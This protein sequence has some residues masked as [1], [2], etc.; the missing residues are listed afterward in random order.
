[1]LSEQL[2]FWSSKFIVTEGD[3]MIDISS[4]AKGM[5]S[6]VPVGA[7]QQ[8]M[9]PYP[10]TFYRFDPCI[11][12]GQNTELDLDQAENLNLVENWLYALMKFYHQLLMDA[13]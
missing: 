9:L 3:V 1:V 11:F 8:T 5:S 12:H 13:R 10:G 2:K 7:Q 4:A 6:T